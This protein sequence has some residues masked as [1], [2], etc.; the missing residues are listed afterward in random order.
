MMDIL[1][2]VLGYLPQYLMPAGF[3]LLW[4][5]RSWRIENG[6]DA[7]LKLGINKMLAWS[8]AWPLVIIITVMPWQMFTW[9]FWLR[10][11]TFPA[12]PKLKFDKPWWRK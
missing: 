8:M 7:G 11:V 12:L 3:C 9:D 4:L 5:I 2:I 10:P 6:G 1:M